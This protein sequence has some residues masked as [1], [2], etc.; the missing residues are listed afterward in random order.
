VLLLVICV[1]WI[2]RSPACIFR[3]A[4]GAL[5]ALKADDKFIQRLDRRI[6]TPSQ[7]KPAGVSAYRGS[8]KRLS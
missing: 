7:R 3:Q 1:L 5:K 2:H 8:K 6:W 4:W